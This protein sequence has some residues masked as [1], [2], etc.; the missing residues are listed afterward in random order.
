MRFFFYATLLQA[1]CNAFAAWLHQRLRPGEAARVTGRLYRVR[2]DVGWH[3]ALVVD[4]GGTPV[5]GMVYEAGDGFSGEDLASLDAYE[6]FDPADPERGDYRRIE[7]TAQTAA[8]PVT[9]QAYVWNRP[10][11]G[12]ASEIAG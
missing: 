8:G 1:D 3:K 2:H 11:D 10:L 4:P 12:L 7:V 9:A 6:D 5:A